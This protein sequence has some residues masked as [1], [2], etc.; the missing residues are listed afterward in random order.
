MKG[1]VQNIE[2]MAVENKDFCRV[3]YTARNCQSSDGNHATF[4]AHHATILEITYE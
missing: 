4:H 3:L 1:F 2:D